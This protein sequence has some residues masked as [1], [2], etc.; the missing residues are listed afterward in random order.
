MA[1]KPT[2]RD[3]SAELVDFISEAERLVYLLRLFLGNI[4][5]ILRAQ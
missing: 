3:I 1:G 4:V 2:F 5:P